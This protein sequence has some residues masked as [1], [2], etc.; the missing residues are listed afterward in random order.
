MTYPFSGFTEIVFTWL[1]NPLW[2]AFILAEV[3]ASAADLEGTSQIN[4]GPLTN[5]TVHS[6]HCIAASFS[7]RG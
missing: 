2:I 3:R 7:D 4:W 5:L 6:N 1:K